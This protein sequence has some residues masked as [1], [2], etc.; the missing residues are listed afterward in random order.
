[1]KQTKTIELTVWSGGFGLGFCHRDRERLLPEKKN[2]YHVTVFLPGGEGL[3]VYTRITESF[4]HSCSEIRFTGVEKK[5]FKEWLKTH[6]GGLKWHR[7]HPINTKPQ[8][9]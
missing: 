5:M 9:S 4:W 6:G 1:M 8:L 2:D 3:T 7:Y